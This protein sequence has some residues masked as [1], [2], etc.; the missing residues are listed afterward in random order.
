[1]SK[2]STHFIAFFQKPRRGLTSILLFSMLF[3]PAANWAAPV[4]SPDSST[5]NR[6]KAPVVSEGILLQIVR[7]FL[8]VDLARLQDD[9]NLKLQPEQQEALMALAERMAPDY[10]DVFS[11]TRIDS[12]RLA[13]LNEEVASELRSGLNPEQFGFVSD[14]AS[15]LM[16]DDGVKLRQLEAFGALAFQFIQS[17]AGQEILKN[18]TSEMSERGR[19]VL[20]ILLGVFSRKA[21]NLRAESTQPR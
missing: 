3:A 17:S 20:N 11:Q 18:S 7:D 4:I 6:T 16:K 5:T 21:E 10:A 15:N 9:P 12:E 2:S 19:S 1:M 14:V 13:S 8:G